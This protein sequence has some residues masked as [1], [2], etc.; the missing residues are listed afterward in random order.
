MKATTVAIHGKPV[1]KKNNNIT[2][3][4]YMYTFD[5]EVGRVVFS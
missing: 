2:R 5:G 4:E 3:E 1:K